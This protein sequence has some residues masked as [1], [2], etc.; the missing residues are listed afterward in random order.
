MMMTLL[1]M[2]TSQN[3]RRVRFSHVVSS[4]KKSLKDMS[5]AF[6]VIV[7]RWLSKMMIKDSQAKTVETN[8]QLC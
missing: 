5:N 3:T 1:T 8:H 2:N 6:E 7:H 4:F